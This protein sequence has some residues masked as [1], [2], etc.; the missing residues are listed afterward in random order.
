MLV[1]GGEQACSDT[2]AVRVVDRSRW[3]AQIAADRLPVV[4]IFLGSEDAIASF[5]RHGDHRLRSLSDCF[6][7][8]HKTVDI[9]RRAIASR[10]PVSFRKRIAFCRR[11]P[12]V[13]IA[14]KVRIS[15]QDIGRVD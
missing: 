7:A 15:T 6:Q 12:M 3:T 14:D 13:W 11:S 4:Q 9:T 5:K 10:L 8:V 2:G 1:V